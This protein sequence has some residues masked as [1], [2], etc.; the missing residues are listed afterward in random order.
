MDTLKFKCFVVMPYSRESLRRLVK[1][2][3]SALTSH[4]VEF[5]FADEAVS[6]AFNLKDQILFLI[7]Q[8]DFLLCFVDEKNPNILW[9]MGIATA[10]GKPFLTV[11][12]GR[13]ADIPVLNGFIRLLGEE[14]GDLH[15]LAN[16]IAQFLGEFSI[17]KNRSAT[18]V[19][20]CHR[21]LDKASVEPL[22][23]ALREKQYIVWY[24]DWNILPGDAIPDKISDG[25]RLSTHFL[26]F[27]SENAP[28]SSWVSKELN[29]ALTLA[30]EKK[31][32]RII[33]VFLDPI[34]RDSTP[35]L[36]K[37]LRGVQFYGRS[38]AEAFK[39]LEKGLQ[40]PADSA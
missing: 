2:L 9:E 8:A 32:P 10:L 11:Y 6:V 12:L 21:S 14:E 24:D 23:E 16:R 19:F 35:I 36:L 40:P 22:A 38:F 3:P 29:T 31:S 27:L 17:L 4:H 1:R 39:A 25:I 20:L 13:D 28:A 34:G 37:E 26:I 7:K 15:F 33:P 30:L 5:V 18:R